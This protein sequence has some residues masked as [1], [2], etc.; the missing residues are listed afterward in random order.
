MLAQTERSVSGLRMDRGIGKGIDWRASLDRLA[1][2]IPWRRRYEHPRGRT[3]MV[4][5]TLAE[6]VEGTILDVGAGRNATP[7]TD[8]F[9]DRYHPLDMGSSYHIDGR[10]DLLGP[11]T[12]VDLERGPLP[13]H[14]RSFGT[15]VCTDVL[16]HIDNIYQA[17]DE[18]FRVADRKV[19][20]SLPN[21][22]VFLPISLIRGRNVSHVAGYGLPPFPK[23]I[24]ERHKYWFNF[25]E[26]ADFLVG[27]VPAEFQV[28]RF[29][30][31]FEYG[32]DSLL[33]GIRPFALLVRT[34]EMGSFFRYVARDFSGAK[35]VIVTL[36]GPLVYALIRP[37]DVLVSGLIWGLGRKTRFY[38]LFC[39]QVWCVFERLP[40]PAQ[41]A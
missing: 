19:V 12:I 41:K 32:S 11:D 15:V 5:E 4:A 23:G 16:E 26:A 8:A 14:D 38:N 27:R 17:Y 21:N 36:I 39:R 28:V 13:F 2:F 25:E 33:C 40:A 29:E 37:L 24:G 22:W 1:S 10:P 18:L 31:R 6:D 30:S 20:I 9:G 3:G 35:R 7:F 34:I